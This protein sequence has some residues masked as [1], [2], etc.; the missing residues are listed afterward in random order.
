MAEE[1]KLSGP[2]FA[3]GVSITEF[4]DGGMMQGH[5]NGEAILVARRGDAYFA[6]GASCTHYGGPLVEGLVAGDT[7]RCP[8][9]HACFS[10]LTGE[11]LRAPA[12][13]PVASWKV[14]T[15]DGKVF[16]REKAPEKKVRPAGSAKAPEHVVIVGGGA[17]G[18]AAAEMLRRQG[19]AGHIAMISADDTVPYDR[20]N[21]SKEFLAGTATESSIP[22]RSM[23]FY[24]EH[25]IELLLNTPVAAIDPGDKT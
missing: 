16:V 18:N 2:D 8:W 23:D 1:K 19:Y 17:A 6:I 9:H 7:V 24:R 11:A 12:L 14:E 10:L 13:D 4:A 15:R 21:L 3:E 25:E 5:A 22:L 20:P